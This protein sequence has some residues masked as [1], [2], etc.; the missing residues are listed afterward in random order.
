MR[1]KDLLFYMFGQLG[2][3]LSARFLFQ[4]ILRFADNSSD[5]GQVLFTASAVGMLLF[6]FRIFDGLCDPIAGLASDRWVQWGRKRQTLLWFSFILPGI[7]LTLCY[8]PAH[9]MP[10]ALRWTILS[11]GL[12]LFFIGYTFYS[13]PYWS[14]VDDYSLEKSHLRA[15]LS[16]M[17]GLGV[18]LAT[19]LGFVLT[20]LL[21]AWL[22]FFTAAFVVAI[23]SSVLM[24]APIF[25]APSTPESQTQSKQQNHSVPHLFLSPFK[26]L[27]FLSILL[28]LGGTQM[29]FTTLTAAVPFVATRLL[30]GQESDVSLLLGALIFTALPVFLVA[31]RISLRFG[32]EK[33]LYTATVLLLCMYAFCCFTGV[34]VFGSA[35]TT[36]AVFFAACGPMIAIVLALE[37]EAITLAAKNHSAAVSM[38]FAAYNLIVKMFNGAALFFTGLLID[39]SRG[40]LGTFAVR[41]M[42]ICAVAMALL[43]LLASL[44]VRKIPVS[45]KN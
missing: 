36:A 41:L 12:L 22:D 20:P 21:I 19:V 7:G 35:R 18:L 43:G 38:Y 13:I 1:K 42:I 6:G 8:I 10:L 30:A 45:L 11:V 24:I 5:S 39:A 23:F 2:V 16:N 9:S 4:W 40:P 32:Y 29:S 34:A 25:A 17:L 28:L 14:L 44:A 37:G 33:T 3:M 31:P 26:D 27:K 15:S